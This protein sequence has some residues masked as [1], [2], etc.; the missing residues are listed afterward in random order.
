MSDPIPAPDQRLDA[1]DLICPLPVLRARK[2]LRPLASGQVLEI[3]TTDPAAPRDF[4]AFCDSA[5]H[6]LISIE[7]APDPEPGPSGAAPAVTVI[8][9]AKGA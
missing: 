8:R 6:R 5:G 2:A 7:P 9:L 1:R 3:L 4:A